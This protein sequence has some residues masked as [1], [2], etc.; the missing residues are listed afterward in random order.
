VNSKRCGQAVALK[1]GNLLKIIFYPIY[2]NCAARYNRGVE[3]RFVIY[4]IQLNIKIE[5]DLL[6]SS[7]LTD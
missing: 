5:E 6:L 7:R 1:T 3:L 4:K 2:G